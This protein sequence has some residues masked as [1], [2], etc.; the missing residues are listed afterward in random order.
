MKTTI[1]TKIFGT[2]VISS[3]ISISN[4]TAQLSKD[5]CSNAIVLT[6]SDSCNYVSGT[7]I[8]A[9]QSTSPM[10][11]NG[12]NGTTSFYDVPC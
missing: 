3:I 12:I 10:S 6:P 7:N 8:G 11:C 5:S 9:K 2:V 4:A 1:F